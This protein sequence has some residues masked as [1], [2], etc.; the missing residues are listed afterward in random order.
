MLDVNMRIM[1][2]GETDIKLGTIFDSVLSKVNK[3]LYHC[4]NLVFATFVERVNKVSQVSMAE[5]LYRMG[6]KITKYLNLPSERG[7]RRE[8]NACSANTVNPLYNE[9]VGP[10]L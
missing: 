1:T 9:R 5:L 7:P 10:P 2:A 6:E 8:K 4:S 3:V